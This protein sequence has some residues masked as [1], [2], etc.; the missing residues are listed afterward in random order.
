MKRLLIGLIGLMFIVLMFSWSLSYAA[1]SVLA[2]GDPKQKSIRQYY[3]TGAAAIAASL[4]IPT[5]GTEIFELISL[6]LALS[7][8]G[9]AANLTVTLN[10]GLG[11]NYDTIYLTQDMTSVNDLVQLYEPGE[12]VFSNL[13]SID[14][15][16]ANGSTRTYGLV[17]KYRL[18]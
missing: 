15:A 9:A 5:Q 8:A 13:D 6:E 10:S 17:I 14:V 3:V 18:K 12:V 7:A 2:V 16:W 11:A 4:S 1:D